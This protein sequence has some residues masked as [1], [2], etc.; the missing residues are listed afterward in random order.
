MHR[1][2]FFQQKKKKKGSRLRPEI[3][4]VALSTP[5]PVTWA[6]FLLV[7]LVEI[8]SAW[9]SKRWVSNSHHQNELKQLFARKKA[10]RIEAE[11]LNNPSTFAKYSKLQRQISAIEKEET[12]L[13]EQVPPPPSHRD[14]FLSY[15]P[16]LLPVRC[17]SA[18]YFVSM[19]ISIVLY[20]VEPIF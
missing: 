15:V 19:V 8:V 4:T 20:V 11:P 17:Y 2:C 13:K 10:L 16:T 1:D 12:V 5:N 9:L 3:M 18:A 7:L 6:V 14:V